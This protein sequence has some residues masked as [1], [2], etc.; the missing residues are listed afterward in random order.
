MCVCVSVYLYLYLYLYIYL[1]LSLSL[2]ISLYLSLSVCLSVCLSV[3]LSISISSFLC[4]SIS[5]SIS[6]SIIIYPSI[7]PSIYSH[8]IPIFSKFNHSEMTSTLNSAPFNAFFCL[9]TKKFNPLNQRPGLEKEGHGSSPSNAPNPLKLSCSHQSNLVAHDDPPCHQAKIK[10]QQP[11]HKNQRE[12][13]SW[14]SYDP[15]YGKLPDCGNHPPL[16][17]F[18]LRMGRS[19]LSALFTGWCSSKWIN[20]GT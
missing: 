13:D 7:Y 12:P 8:W 9:S 15:L 18:P 11:P 20:I 17:D 19:P 2:S 16:A 1:Y 10:H 6:L 5:I 3:Y 4:I 14:W